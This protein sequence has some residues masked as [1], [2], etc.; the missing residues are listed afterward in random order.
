M[1]LN[2][3]YLAGSV[4]TPLGSF[5]GAF[6]EVSAVRLGIT[7][8]RA[9]LA[10]SGVAADEI[11]EVYFGNILSAG[12]LPNPARQIA[13]G[14][15]LPQSVPATTVNILCGSGMKALALAAQEIE[16]GA[17][18]ITLAGGVENMTRAPYLLEKGRTGYRLGHG[19]IYDS[20]LRDALI[21]PFGGEHM[22]VYAERAAERYG[23]TREQQDDYA[24]ES[25]RRAIRASE[26]GTFAR[27]IAPVEVAGR[28]GAMTIVE[29]DE[30]PARFNEAKFRQ[31]SPA[32]AKNGTITAGN[33]S[34]INDGA[35]AALLL[36]S[37]KAQRHGIQLDARV[38]GFALHAHEPEWFTLAPI[39]AMNKLMKELGWSVAEVDLFEINEA[40]AVVPMAAMRELCI[41]HDK[42]NIHGGAVCIGHPIGA[43]GARVVATLVNALRTHGKKRGIASLCI[44]GGMGIAMA[45]ELV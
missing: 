18:D 10:R 8:A 4:R 35:A 44:G 40:F 39:G 22:G 20:M 42:V 24:I 12:L 23:F 31:L 25:Y 37:A 11:E 7:A 27:E 15:G 5:C 1:I 17:I 16:N 30:E 43:S 26:D 13:L 32:F 19:E 33:A 36:S 29:R 41:P 38:L 21:D 3:T 14:A 45:L 2:D 9:A 6:S 34:S 28:K